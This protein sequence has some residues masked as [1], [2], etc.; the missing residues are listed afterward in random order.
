LERRVRDLV[1]QP[2]GELRLQGRLH[3][4][5]AEPAV[6]RGICLEAAARSAAAPRLLRD[7]AYART[8]EPRLVKALLGGLGAP[9]RVEELCRGRALAWKAEAWLRQRLSD[10]PTISH[11]C[12]ALDASER[13]LHEAFRRHL[14]T[15]PKAYLKTLRLNAARHDLV[16][17]ETR[18]TDVAL[19]WGFLH[20]GWFSQDYRRLFGESPRQTLER[21]RADRERLPVKRGALLAVGA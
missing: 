9:E 21:G 10:P 7:T 6:L 14:D 15:T 4:L 12:R 11:L 2:L 8:L 20:F 13:T 1:G 5:R 18:V 19:D 3:G 16:K 17:G